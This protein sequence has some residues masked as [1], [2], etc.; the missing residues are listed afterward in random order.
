[1][2]CVA[3]RA[4]AVCICAAAYLSPLPNCFAVRNLLQ[5]G[6]AGA[7]APPPRATRFPLQPGSS[8]SGG[9]AGAWRWAG[10]PCSACCRPQL[11]V[12]ARQYGSGLGGQSLHRWQPGLA[13]RMYSDAVAHCTLCRAGMCSTCSACTP[14]TPARQEAMWRRQSL[15]LAPAAATALAIW[16]LGKQ[17]AAWAQL[18]LATTRPVSQ[19]HAVLLLALPCACRC[20]QLWVIAASHLSCLS[21]CPPCSGARPAARGACCG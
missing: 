17:L 13:E 10:G 11:Q 20:Q 5:L 4:S 18:C 8:D 12:G 2:P 3:C 7:A 19:R 9:A 6:A 15:Q 1:M 21:L 16:C 14:E